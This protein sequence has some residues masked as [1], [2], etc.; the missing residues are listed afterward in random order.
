MTTVRETRLS[1]WIEG[2]PAVPPMYHQNSDTDILFE[3]EGLVPP[4]LLDP[5]DP[6]WAP[7][8]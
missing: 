4:R 3:M 1:G 5:R 6:M 8:K 7:G 2:L